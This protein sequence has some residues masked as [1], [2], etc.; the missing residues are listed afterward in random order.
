MTQTLDPAKVDSNETTTTCPPIELNVLNGDDSGIDTDVFTFVQSTSIFSIESSEISKM[1][2]YNLKL[3]AKYAG[4][5]YSHITELSFTVTIDDPC[6][7]ADLTILPTILDSLTTQHISYKI[8][9]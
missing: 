1:D 4:E 5:E 2:T 7:L 8:G 9:Y 3:T 6:V